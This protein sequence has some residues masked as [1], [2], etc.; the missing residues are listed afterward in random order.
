MNSALILLVSGNYCILDDFNRIFK[1]CLRGLCPEKCPE[2]LKFS[3]PEKNLLC[4][5][6]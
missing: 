6:L 4:P 1:A 5:G 3:C 2:F